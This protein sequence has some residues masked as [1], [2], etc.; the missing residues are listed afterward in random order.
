ML[1]NWSYSSSSNDIFFLDRDMLMNWSYSSSSNDHFFN[2][3]RHA[4]ELIIFFF[5]KWSFF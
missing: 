3:Q 5:F 4:H 2:R 1:M